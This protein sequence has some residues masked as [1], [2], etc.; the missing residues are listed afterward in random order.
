MQIDLNCD[1]GE[2]DKLSQGHNDAV[3]MPFISSC[4]IACGY[5]AGNQSVIT[6]TVSLALKNKVNI[7]AHPSYP[8]R[9]NFGRMA[10]QM[11]A[12]DLKPIIIKQIQQVK[13]AAENQ[14]GRLSHVKPHGALYNQAANDLALACVLLEAVSE[15]DS[16]LM[17]MGLAHS[18]MEQAA[19]EFGVQFIAEGFVDRAYTQAGKLVPRT[20]AGAV[21]KDPNLMLKRVLQMLKEHCVEAVS[22]EKISLQLQTLCLHGDH[23]DAIQTAQ[24][25]NQGL[26][27]AGFSIRAPLLKEHES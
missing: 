5:H 23:E 22:G 2:Y 26:K 10:M 27:K 11:S 7:G 14:G 1:L 3:I 25:I 20:E 18:E 21:I 8:D 6:H 15:V 19:R 24:M 13:L 12:K 4:N 16:S 9:E 17:F